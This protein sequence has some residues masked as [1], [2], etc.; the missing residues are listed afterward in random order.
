MLKYYSQFYAVREVGNL[1]EGKNEGGR[2]HGCRCEGK[3]KRRVG[4][5]LD[6]FKVPF[7]ISVVR[8]GWK[9]SDQNLSSRKEEESVLS[10]LRQRIGRRKKER[11]ILQPRR[12]PCDDAAHPGGRLK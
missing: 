4:F 12:M 11:E 5:F 2:E 3:C 10:R 9:Q 1:R 8:C 7:I 6:L